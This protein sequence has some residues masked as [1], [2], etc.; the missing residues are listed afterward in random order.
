MKRSVAVAMACLIVLPNVTIMST[1]AIDHS[2]DCDFE[3]VLHCSTRTGGCNNVTPVPV[4]STTR[5]GGSKGV[6]P[7]PLYCFL[8][9]HTKNVSVVVDSNQALDIK[10]GRFTFQSLT[11]LGRTLRKGTLILKAT[12]Y[13]DAPLANDYANLSGRA[14]AEDKNCSDARLSAYDESV[15]SHVKLLQNWLI[16]PRKSISITLPVSGISWLHV[17]VAAANNGCQRPPTIA[18]NANLS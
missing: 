3:T 10:S 11:F 6:G 17:S 9:H 8:L 15:S 2:N 18:L 13:G 7:A 16:K 1:S 5:V 12:A 14:W 4:H